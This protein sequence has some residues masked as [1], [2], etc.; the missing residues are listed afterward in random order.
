[1]TKQRLPRFF[2]RD[3]EVRPT[4]RKGRGMFATVEIPA[5]TIIERAPVLLIPGD[6]ADEMLTSFLAHYIFR[7][8]RGRQFVIGLGYT[9]LYN[10]SRSPNAEFSVS[11]DA[12]FIKARRRIRP[13][14]EVTVAYGW[15]ANEWA[16]VGGRID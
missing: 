9:S 16:Q 11:K 7:T 12:L 2:Q 10:H 8:D 3:V 4:R 5:R 15:T 6:E 13:G 1:M 14:E